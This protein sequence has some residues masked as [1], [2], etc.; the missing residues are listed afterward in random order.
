MIKVT[1][2]FIKSEL[3]R[4]VHVQITVSWYVKL[5]LSVKY[6]GLAL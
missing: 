1:K 5:C 6:K 3:I 4:V 2:Q